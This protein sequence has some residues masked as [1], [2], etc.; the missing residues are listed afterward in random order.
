MSNKKEPRDNRIKA[1]NPGEASG[2]VDLE[3]L[4]KLYADD[5]DEFE[6]SDEVSLEDLSKSYAKVVSNDSGNAIAGTTYD[7]SDDEIQ[8]FDPLEEELEEENA[9]PV[10]PISIVEAVLLVGR[11]D[12]GPISATEIAA[13]MRGVTEAEVDQLVAEL[14]EDY[15]LNRRA[16]H[17]AMVGGAY[18]LELAQDLTEVRDRFWG[19]TRDIRLNQAAIDCLAL[20]AYQPGITR[21]KLD[22]QRGQPSGSVLNQLVRRELLEMRREKD[23]KKVEPHYYPTSRMLSLV[24]LESLEDLPTVEDW[25]G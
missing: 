16:F 22:Q 21:D 19:P 7:S 11:P 24:G 2:E 25:N 12:G 23:D 10:S 15:A 18:R 14:N 5:F 6:D 9:I 20:V 13:L 3:R 8:I 1:H 17:V 4:A